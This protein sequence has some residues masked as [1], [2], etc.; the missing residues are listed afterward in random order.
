MKKRLVGRTSHPSY[1]LKT[2]TVRESDSLS[3]KNNAIREL[4]EKGKMW[5]NALLV[6]LVLF[7]ARAAAQGDVPSCV[8]NCGTVAAQAV[9]CASMYVYFPIPLPSRVVAERTLTSGR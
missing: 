8:S 4:K 6:G 5:G 3:L 9:G 7:V 1:P 2:A